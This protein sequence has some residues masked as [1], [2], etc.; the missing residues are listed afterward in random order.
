MT[1]SA[2]ID[3][4]SA[5]AP[6][7][8]VIP[9]WLPSGTLMDTRPRLKTVLLISRV[10]THGQGPDTCQVYTH[11]NHSVEEFSEVVVPHI[12]MSYPEAALDS[13]THAAFLELAR[14]PSSV[15]VD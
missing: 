7:R 15:A 1:T 14:S 2:H 4:T 8:S 13:V 6:R 3:D 12:D 10:S 5:V 9:R 11:R